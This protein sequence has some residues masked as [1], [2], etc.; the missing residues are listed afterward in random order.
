M[1]DNLSPE[2]GSEP[3]DLSL[4][5]VA[6]Q[7]AAKPVEKQEEEPEV[8]ATEQQQETPDDEAVEPTEEEAV[9]EEGDDASQE[10]AE[11]EAKDDLLVKLADGSKLT[12]AALKAEAEQVKTENARI[13]QEAAKERR[14]LQQYSESVRGFYDALIDDLSS[15]LPPE[16]NPALMYGTLEQQM[17]FN[18]EKFHRESQ[19][20]Y[21]RNLFQAREALK[22]SEAKISE[23]DAQRYQENERA[24]LIKANPNLK[25]PTR[26]KAAMDK[27]KTYLKSVG[28]DDA[29]IDSTHDA[30][31]L[32]VAMDAAYGKEARENAQKAKV[33]LKTVTAKT[34]VTTRPVH[35]NSLKAITKTNAL[36]RAQSSGSIDDVLKAMLG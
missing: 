9:E 3:A 11:L 32:Q 23:A 27:T 17:Q 28:F 34:P 25:D 6:K 36:K 20:E 21:M 15:K 24:A 16:P 10:D 19:I 30:K 22:E 29:L 35:P 13:S 14:E 31:M 4:D 5:D 2:T 8:E 12:V 1:A 26:F 33:Q 7:M 18:R